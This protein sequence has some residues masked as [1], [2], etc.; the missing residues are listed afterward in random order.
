MN[1]DISIDIH[2]SKLRQGRSFH[3]DELQ[4]MQES[5]RYGIWHPRYIIPRRNFGY[6]KPFVDRQLPK[7]KPSVPLF[8]K[9]VHRLRDGFEK[10]SIRGTFPRAS[11]GLVR[12][13]NYI[14]TANQSYDDIETS[15][16]YRWY[17]ATDHV[18]SASYSPNR[19]MT[20]GQHRS[21]RNYGSEDESVYTYSEDDNYS[22]YKKWH[23]EI[24]NNSFVQEDNQ[25]QH[26]TSTTT[27][28]NIYSD[29]NE[30][31]TNYLRVDSDIN[32]SVNNKNT[33]PSY[34]DNYNDNTID[35]KPRTDIKLL[36]VSSDEFDS[37][38]DSRVPKPFL[39]ISSIDVSNNPQQSVLLHDFSIVNQFSNNNV[40]DFSLIKKLEDDI[41][42]EDKPVDEE[43]Q[44]NA[45]LK[46]L[47]DQQKR[48]STNDN[49]NN[50]KTVSKSIDNSVI[51]NNSNVP[52][53]SI[54]TRNSPNSKSTSSSPKKRSNS[55]SPNRNIK[56]IF[57]TP[58]KKENDETY[59]EIDPDLMSPKR[60][61]LHDLA[62]TPTHPRYMA[63]KPEH[64]DKTY[65]YNPLKNIMNK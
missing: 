44:M 37:L 2:D 50:D 20:K 62:Y 13:K 51:F 26:S 55:E 15:K 4:Q 8:D 24:F 25:I 7:N 47:D 46:W 30:D 27:T 38:R 58:P 60:F 1:S 11:R 29:L 3:F 39:D 16:D 41:I 19:R 34:D 5:E 35:I 40:S 12:D 61:T 18:R 32:I 9:M 42:E 33:N 21:R 14:H 63:M 56:F 10:A 43:S 48:N 6:S 22:G 17:N 57:S 65:L 53:K 45:Y 49:T 36:D 28:T 54:L 23:P 59:A 52:L 64:I 31:T